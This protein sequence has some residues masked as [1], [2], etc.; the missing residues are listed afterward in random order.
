MTQ[1][2]QPH[3]DD[4]SSEVSIADDGVDSIVKDHLL[5]LAD[6]AA[7]AE[8]LT[9]EES[10]ARV[11]ATYKIG[12]MTKGELMSRLA[13]IPS[14][15]DDARLI[16][17]SLD[18]LFSK[19]LL[20]YALKMLELI[21]VIKTSGESGSTPREDSQ[22]AAL[23]ASS[24]LIAVAGNTPSS[25]HS[26]RSSVVSEDDLRVDDGEIFWRG[27]YMEQIVGHRFYIEEA[28]GLS[29]PLLLEDKVRCAVEFSAVRLAE[30]LGGHVSILSGLFFVWSEDALVA[31]RAII[32]SANAILRSDDVNAALLE[33]RREAKA[34]LGDRLSS[35]DAGHLT[36]LL[37]VDSL[38]GQAR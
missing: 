31:K 38:E 29:S 35:M 5:A 4:D 6:D 11:L 17:G 14:T 20:C 10:L 25:E 19:D 7:T 22:I 18:S 12:A 21:A 28:I 2:K 8:P 16:L 30:D 34:I 33:A 36:E 9:I 32:D 37:A 27:S 23:R 15:L 1:D 13:R 26:R 3:L 24:R